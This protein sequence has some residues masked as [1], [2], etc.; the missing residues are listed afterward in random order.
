MGQLMKC[1]VMGKLNNSGNLP[2]CHSFHHKFHMNWPG[3]EPGLLWWQ[4]G[5]C[6]LEVWNNLCLMQC[7]IS[8]QGK[9]ICFMGNVQA[10]KLAEEIC[11]FSLSN[12]YIDIYFFIHFISYFF[13]IIPYIPES[14]PSPF[15]QPRGQK[16]DA[17]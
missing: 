11:I 17:D 13:Q 2:Q 8:I 5:N 15:L 16:S 7:F 3:I 10:L 9:S 12:E 6:T 4:T 14:N 1:E